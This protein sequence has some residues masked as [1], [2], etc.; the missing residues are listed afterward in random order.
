[1][2]TFIWYSNFVWWWLFVLKL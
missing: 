1:M 2:L